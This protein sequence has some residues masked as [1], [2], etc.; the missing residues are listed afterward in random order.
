MR[1]KV[2]LWENKSVTQVEGFPIIVQVFLI[3]FEPMI[4][5]AILLSKSW[6][7]EKCTVFCPIQ[8]LICLLLPQSWHGVHTD[9]ELHW[10]IKSILSCAPQQKRHLRWCTVTGH[11]TPVKFCGCTGGS[12]KMARIKLW[13]WVVVLLGCQ[14]G[15]HTALGPLLT[16]WSPQ[17]TQITVAKTSL[18]LQQ[19]YKVRSRNPL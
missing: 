10:L 8:P 1:I 12:S 13:R 7:D 4:N 15:R 11:W 2:I 3:I 19:G 9:R 16:F 17:L 6:V 14:P 18:Q 5:F